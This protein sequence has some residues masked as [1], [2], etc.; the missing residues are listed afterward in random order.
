MAK[1]QMIKPGLPAGGS[2]SSIWASSCECVSDSRNDTGQGL[3]RFGFRVFGLQG[4]LEFGTWNLEFAF[5]PW[6]GPRIGMCGSG[7]SDES[8][9]VE[10]SWMV[11]QVQ[12]VGETGW[13]RET[14]SG[15]HQY[16]GT[17]SRIFLVVVEAGG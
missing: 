5:P 17:S 2:V 11:V 6:R 14:V 13:G 15:C 8:G 16:P 9:E 12:M 3:S 7:V 1:I 10:M 4:S